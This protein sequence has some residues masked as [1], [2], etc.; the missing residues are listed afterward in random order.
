M[1][2]KLNAISEEDEERIFTLKF[3]LQ[4]KIKEYK[5]T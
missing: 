1:Y 4:H 3:A 2:A 5:N